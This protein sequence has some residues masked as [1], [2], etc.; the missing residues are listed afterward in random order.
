[1][2]SRVDQNRAVVHDRV[3]IVPYAIFRR[4]IVIGD[5]RI[6]QNRADPDVLVIS[7]G[8][9]ALLDDIT[10]KA[11][12]L[13]D[14]ENPVNS[15]DH[16]ANDAADHG[17]DRTGRSLALSGALINSADDPLG[18]RHDRKRDGGNN[19]KNSDKAADHDISQRYWLR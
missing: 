12:S 11:R 5:A 17:A 10:V 6:G 19:G 16:A 3:A 7:I 15:S 14:A 18:L 13:V 1:V 4:H 2:G 8:R 9:A